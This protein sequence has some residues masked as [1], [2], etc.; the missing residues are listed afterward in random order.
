MTAGIKQ[1]KQFVT[2]HIHENI[3]LD[4]LS[5]YVYLSRFHFSR[6]FKKMTGETP[7]TFIINTKIQ[8]AEQ[9]LINSDLKIR[10]IAEQVGYEPERFCSLF[11]QKT[12]HTPTAYR[13]RYRRE[14]SL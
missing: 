9:L 13:V 2:E 1:I 6:E 14:T 10:E 7:K 4:M 3:T 11:H 12:G 5:G 8:Y